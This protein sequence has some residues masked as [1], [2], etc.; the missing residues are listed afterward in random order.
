MARENAR[1][2]KIA[3][4][5]VLYFILS[6][7]Q[8]MAVETL[9]MPIHLASPDSLKPSIFHRLFYAYWILAA[10]SFTVMISSIGVFLYDTLRQS[11]QEVKKSLNLTSNSNNG[12]DNSFL[13]RKVS[14]YIAGGQYV[15]LATS[16]SGVG[17]GAMTDTSYTVGSLN[18]ID[19]KQLSTEERRFF[20]P[21]GSFFFLSEGEKFAS[22][23]LLKNALAANNTFVFPQTMQ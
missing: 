15:I 14:S 8:V 16:S 9:S 6:I 2:I 20:K 23:Q 10:I 11:L 3:G 12:G 18:R 5:K 7:F 1:Q 19:T 21:Q 17:A 4:K 13:V 22:E